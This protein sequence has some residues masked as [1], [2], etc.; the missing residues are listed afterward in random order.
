MTLLS[1]ASS[2]AVSRSGSIAVGDSA[3]TLI[4]HLQHRFAAH[5]A[6]GQQN[7]EVVEHVGGLLGDA[8]VR[9]L[10]RGAGDLLALLHHLLA[11]HRRVLEQLNGVA[12]LWTL[13]GAVGKHAAEARD[14]LEGDGRRLRGPVAIG[15]GGLTGS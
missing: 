11:D 2:R 9:F 8:L 5:P 14:R 3:S 13:A 4:E 10:A 1:L 6:R 15:N 7:L 12:A